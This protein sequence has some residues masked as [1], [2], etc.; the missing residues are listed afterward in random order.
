M[1]VGWKMI[2]NQRLLGREVFQVQSES[3]RA[4]EQRQHTACIARLARLR[5]FKHDRDDRVY[6]TGS[7]LQHNERT[8]ERATQHGNDAT[9]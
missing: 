5:S 4:N 3:E 6:G 8:K 1:A 7:A 9:R 2:G